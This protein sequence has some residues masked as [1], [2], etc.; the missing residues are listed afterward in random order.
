MAQFRST[1]DILDLALQKAGEVTNGNSPYETQALNYLNRVHFALVAGGT[2]PLG[3]DTSVQID[4]V[5]PW[6]KAKSP[7][8]L[9]L[10]PKYET[11]TVTVTQGSE[12]ITFTD[13]PSYSVRGWHFRI[14][15]REEWFKIASHTAASTSI[16]L[17]GA[18]T[19]DSGSGLNFEIVKLDYELVPDYIVVNPGNNKFQFRK[20]AGVTLTSTLTSG[21]YTPADLISHVATQ[22]TTTAAGPTITGSYDDVTRKFTL[23][24]NLA[25]GT[26][27]Q[28]VGN[29]DQSGFSIH[30]TLGYDDEAQTGA[31]SYTSVYVL[32]GL[33]RIVEPFK[34]HRG[35]S[36]EGSIYGVDAESFQ[37][38]Y[39]FALIEEGL[40]TRFATVCEKTDGTFTVRFNRFPQEKTRVEVE[41]VPIPRDL[42]DDSMSIPLVP[43]KHVDVLE[44]AATFYLLLDKSDDRAQMYANLLQGKLNAMIAQHRGSQVRAGKHFG[45][46]I[47]RPDLITR[48]RKR[49]EFG[50]VD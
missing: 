12:A 28:I 5:W 27:F 20:A 46:I 3:K 1:A 24:S 16:E 40:P 7:L 50:E 30:K 4:E 41:Y 37:R 49:L 29:G 21:T 17:D 14:E 35:S 39:P 13:A 45:E 26:V 6:S 44:D 31:S 23:T 10:Q 34:M 15:G 32:G 47:S 9:E 25:G 42:K 18:Y 33:C 8:I 19:E 22:A 48:G 43:R 11:G 2:I 38:N 36:H